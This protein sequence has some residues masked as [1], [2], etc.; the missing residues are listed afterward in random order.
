[1]KFSGE[2]V[3]SGKEARLFL[4]G[5]E[6]A[7][8]KS[9]EAIIEK[10]KAEIPILGRR[11]KGHK[12]S[13]VSGTGTLTLYKVTSKFSRMM[14]EYIRTGRDV[15]FTLQSVLDDKGADRG[16]ERVTLYHCNMDSVKIG[17]LDA[18]ADALEEEIPFTFE[19]ADLPE[20]LRDNF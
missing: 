19:G 6:V 9:Y 14:L 15:Y 16:T 20:S 11:F 12:T 17:Q 18:E 8:A 7:Y 5:E 2:N 10:T 13:G 1:M 3:I 4:D